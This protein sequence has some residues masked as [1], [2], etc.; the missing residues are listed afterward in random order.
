MTDLRE[1]IVQVL[2]N[3]GWTCDYHEPDNQCVECA[4]LHGATADKVMATIHEH[5]DIKAAT[6]AMGEALSR[7]VVMPGAS[8][9]IP[10]VEATIEA[11]LTPGDTE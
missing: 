1:A 11:A 10:V 6:T 8:K 2:W 9:L 3:D 7:L 4:G 5:A